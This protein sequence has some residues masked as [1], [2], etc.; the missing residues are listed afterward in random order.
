[1]HP[2]FRLLA[3]TV[4]FVA[5][6][7]D[8]PDVSTISSTRIVANR[9][10]ANRIVANKLAAG[11]VAAAKLSASEVASGSFIVNLDAAGQLLSTQGGREVFAALVA[12]ALPETSMLEATLADGTFD[13]F[14][15]VGLAPEWVAHPLYADSKR[16]VSACIFARVNAVEVPI[17]VSMRGPSPALGTDSDER[18][19]FPLQEGAFYG[20]YFTPKDEPIDWYACRGVDKAQGNAGDLVSRNCAAPDP[21]KPGFT[22][23]GFTYSGDCGLLGSTHACELFALGG[24][25][26]QRCHGEPTTGGKFPLGSP[27]FSQVITT[28]VRL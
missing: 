25:F 5:A 8:G 4:P 20:N 13:F 2:V 1:M 11:K 28:Y 22:L 24:T 17:P 12:C 9:I 10:V 14:G 26:F 16:W 18:S 21:A 7:V 19:A 23:C 6:C 3:V 15:D 27:S